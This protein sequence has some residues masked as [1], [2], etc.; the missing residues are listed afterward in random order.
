LH[1]SSRAGTT[2]ATSESSLSAAIE[3][4]VQARNTVHE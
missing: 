2:G 3:L 4:N 1:R